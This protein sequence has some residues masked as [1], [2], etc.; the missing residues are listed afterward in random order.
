MH[1]SS[2]IP[3]FEAS[4]AER[5]SAVLRAAKRLHRQA[6]APSLAQSLPVL[7]RLLAA[8]LLQG[9]TLPQLFEQRALVQR[10]HVLR[11]LA[12]EAGFNH[13]E[14]YRAA[15]L[16]DAEQPHLPL[17]VVAA[18]AGYPNFWF[19]NMQQAQ[20]HVRVRGGR[21]VQVGAQAVVLP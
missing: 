16:S 4:G 14:L 6:A 5:V 20:A 13:W 11:M 7:R 3:S 19:S 18:H 8:Q 1:I 17:E 12:Q 9:L 2:S 10:K 21:A 15:L